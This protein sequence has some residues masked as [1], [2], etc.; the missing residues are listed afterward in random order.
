[1]SVFLQ[2]I[3]TQTVGA[4]G[5]ASITFN[6]I[7]QTF[8]DLKIVSSARC[9]GA[10]SG[11]FTIDAVFNSIA[12]GYSFTTAVGTPTGPL[13]Q[14]GT[15]QTS[16]RIGRFATTTQTASTFASSQAYIPNYASANFKSII[17]DASLESNDSTFFN[18]NL[19][20]VLWSNTA[21]ITSITLSPTTGTIVQHSTF[22]LYGI[23]KG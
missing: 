1:M 8:T 21:A 20:A 2:P 6:N 5:A 16:A 15:S 11:G 23:T 7:P 17:V 18:N 4:G 22:T 10:S 14:R 13:S 3:Y 19:F 12:T 9:D